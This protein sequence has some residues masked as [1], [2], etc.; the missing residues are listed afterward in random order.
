MGRCAGRRRRREDGREPGTV[1][2]RWTGARVRVT[3]GGQEAGH[4]YCV[5]AVT[6]RDDDRVGSAGSGVGTPQYRP[7]VEHGGQPSPDPELIELCRTSHPRLVGSLRLVCGDRA[8]AEDL[9]Q[10]ALVRLWQHWARVR[11]LES[12]EAWAFHVA[13]NLARSWAR[14]RT[15]YRAALRRLAAASSLAVPEHAAAAAVDVRAAVAALPLRQR[16]APPI[17][18]SAV[19]PPSV[20]AQ[21]GAQPGGRR[22]D[23]RVPDRGEAR[24]DLRRRVARRVHDGRLLPVD[25]HR[26]LGTGLDVGDCDREHR[27]HDPDVVARETRGL[28]LQLDLV[29]RRR[30]SDLRRGRR[31]AETAAARA[32]IARA[33]DSA[34]G[35]GLRERRNR[36]AGST[37][38]HSATAIVTTRGL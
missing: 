6:E 32:G 1:P 3:T 2:A 13:V 14:R 19:Q 24:L 35:S 4:P 27:P 33:S 36:A 28:D 16:V 31:R 7:R 18:H 20:S 29:R 17:V 34:K 15:V 26:K 22:H 37:N 5:V 23:P 25:A 30:L 11:G 10:E 21:L 38:T 12:P 9:A 8:A